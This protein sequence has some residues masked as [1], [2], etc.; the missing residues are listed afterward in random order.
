MCPLVD[1]ESR[2]AIVKL[3]DWQAEI[4]IHKCSPD[5]DGESFYIYLLAPAFNQTA[6]CAGEGVPCPKCYA[7]NGSECVG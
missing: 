3:T 2:T 4:S 1:N 6:Y 7:Y 5:V